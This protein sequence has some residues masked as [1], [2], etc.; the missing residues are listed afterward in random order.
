MCLTI[1]RHIARHINWFY[2]IRIHSYGVGGDL[3]TCA[4]CLNIIREKE[5]KH[6]AEEAIQSC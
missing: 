1:V 4:E 2:E 6:A 3:L 5:M